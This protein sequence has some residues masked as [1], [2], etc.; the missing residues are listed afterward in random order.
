MRQHPQQPGKNLPQAIIDLAAMLKDPD[1]LKSVLQ[2]A[3]D[4]NATNKLT[5][6]E[7]AELEAANQTLADADEARKILDANL[8][9]YNSDKSTLAIATS[10]VMAREKLADKRDSEQVAFSNDLNRQ[11]KAQQLEDK[12]LGDLSK[13]LSAGQEELRSAQAALQAREDAVKEREEVFKK[14]SGMLANAG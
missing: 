10:S 5:E 12:R 8:E 7:I 3:K 4:I 11:Q 2:A 9:K 6:D 1:W 13:Q 14:A